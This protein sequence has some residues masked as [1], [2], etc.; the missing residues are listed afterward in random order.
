MKKMLSFFLLTILF[1]TQVNFVLSATPTPIPSGTFGSLQ[2]GTSCGVADA[3]GDAGKCC[4]YNPTTNS[5]IPQT[6]SAAIDAVLN[7]VNG[8][9]NGRAFGDFNNYTKSLIQACVSGG[10]S[11]PGDIGNPNCRCLSPTL[12]PLTSL[13]KYCDNITSGSGEVGQC[14][15]CLQQ[16]GIWTGIGCVYPDIKD[17][18]QKTVFGFGIG[19]AGG[20]AFLCIIYAAFQLQTSQGNPEKIKKSQEMLTSCIM[21]L[22][23]II[24]SVFILRLIGVSIIQIPGF[25]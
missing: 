15:S 18:I 17:F 7:I 10:P 8:L 9:N 24:F 2:P 12:S 22:M 23:L 11:T 21:G 16:G 1:L 3:S 4:N 25:K 19:L 14:N 13:T 6:G 5:P 20:I